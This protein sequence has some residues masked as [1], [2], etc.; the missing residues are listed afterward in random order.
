MLKPFLWYWL[1]FSFI[2]VEKKIVY[3]SKISEIAFK[4][5]RGSIGGCAMSV[6][7]RGFEAQ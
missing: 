3:L 6:E 4:C 1:Q 2:P 5:P 7:D